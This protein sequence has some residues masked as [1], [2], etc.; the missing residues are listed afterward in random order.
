[1]DLA[2]KRCFVDYIFAFAEKY[3]D[4]LILRN[5]EKLPEEEGHDIDLLICEDELFKTDHLIKELHSHFVF[6]GFVRDDYYGLRSYSFVVGGTILHL[7]FFYKIQWNRYVFIDTKKALLRKERYKNSYWVLNKQDLQYYCWFNFVR[8]KGNLKEKYV[9]HANEWEVKYNKNKN[10]DIQKKSPRD[11]RRQLIIN[12]IQEIGILQFILNSV[13]N[14][15]SKRRKLFRMDGRIYVMDDLNNPNV[16]AV[17]Q[18]CCC[19][20]TDINKC[21]ELSPIKAF[22]LLYFEHSIG[23]SPKIWNKIWWHRFVPSVY[24]IYRSED[25]GNMVYNIYRGVEI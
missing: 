13:H 24:V 4:Y 5:Y 18:F 11:N 17:R 21:N 16:L 22:K 2:I 19:K 14:I 1:M 6:R 3:F 10:I 8:S 25:L 20:R 12:I 15:N 23:V 9:I 7:D